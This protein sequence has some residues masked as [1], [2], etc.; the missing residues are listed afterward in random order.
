[1]FLEG[2]RMSGHPSSATFNH[3]QKRSQK[4]PCYKSLVCALSRNV[5]KP[6]TSTDDAVS[7]RSLIEVVQ[8]TPPVRNQDHRPVRSQD[9]RPVRGQDHPSCDSRPS[10]SHRTSRTR[11]ARLPLCTARR[12]APVQSGR[13][14]CPHP[15]RI[16][17]R[18]Q[19]RT[20]R[21]CMS[22]CRWRARCT[23]CRCRRSAYINQLT[24]PA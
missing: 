6:D 2:L 14:T 19:S 8:L 22:A 16:P 5:C 24:P 18:T 17:H 1:M 23:A 20:R 11:R 4:K 3:A 7:F 12:T 15:S 10:L 13:H 21:R 9:H